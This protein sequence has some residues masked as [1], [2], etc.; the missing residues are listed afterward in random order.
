M[1]EKTI[2]EA[3]ATIK[4]IG[5]DKFC[6]SLNVGENPCPLWAEGIK[7]T[8]SYCEYCKDNREKILKE[9]DKQFRK[10]KLEKLLNG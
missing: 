7:H 4:R 6:A 2:K 3:Y 9:L 1:K 5:F 8:I 10:E